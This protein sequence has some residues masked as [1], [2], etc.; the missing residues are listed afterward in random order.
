MRRVLEDIWHSRI[1]CFKFCDF[2][3]SV[4]ESIEEGTL[5]NPRYIFVEAA[6]ILTNLYASAYS[7]IVCISQKRIK[8]AIHII[9][10]KFHTICF[11][12]PN[13]EIVG[14]QA[15]SC[16]SHMGS[17]LWRLEVRVIIVLPL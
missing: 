5:V 1:Y 10:T 14:S 9:E 6:S 12:G 15:Y 2:H 16:T 17:V 8:I 4:I 11:V 3:V 7:Q 13:V